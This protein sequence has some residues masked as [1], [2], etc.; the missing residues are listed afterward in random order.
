M[1]VREC[2]ADK[3]WSSASST[4]SGL[5]VIDSLHLGT[6]H[7]SSVTKRRARGEDI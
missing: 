3:A 4:S 2:I 5:Q 7:C 1:K 6:V